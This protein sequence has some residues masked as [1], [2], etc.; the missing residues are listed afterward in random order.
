MRTQN[1]I[2][3]NVSTCRSM[4]GCKLTNKSIRV[5]DIYLSSSFL[6]LPLTVKPWLWRRLLSNLLRS[7]SIVTKVSFSFSLAVIFL[8]LLWWLYVPFWTNISK[9]SFYLIIKNPR[10]GSFGG[11]K[12]QNRVSAL[13]AVGLSSGLGSRRQSLFICHSAIVSHLLI[14]TSYCL[15][16]L[17]LQSFIALFFK[18][19]SCFHGISNLVY[20]SNGLGFAALNCSFIEYIICMQPYNCKRS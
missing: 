8:I 14:L 9:P 16:D 15:L 3:W 7:I 18:S 2:R 20:A 6:L 17:L 10:S 1:E 5:V 12:R 4:I 11:I 13:S 19:C